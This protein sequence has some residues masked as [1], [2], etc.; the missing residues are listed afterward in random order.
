MYHLDPLCK[1]WVINIMQFKLSVGKWYT[2]VRLLYTTIWQYG[3][4]VRGH[5]N[6][7]SGVVRKRDM[8]VRMLFD[9]CTLL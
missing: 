6:V 7:P 2:V 3:R 9:G 5:R 1:G 8:S 4:P